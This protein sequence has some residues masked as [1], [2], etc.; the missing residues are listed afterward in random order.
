MLQYPAVLLFIRQ[1]VVNTDPGG[2]D[3]QNAA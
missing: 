1:I 3:W 2:M